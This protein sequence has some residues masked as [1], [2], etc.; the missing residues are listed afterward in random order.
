MIQV[1]LQEVDLSAA[2]NSLRDVNILC[3]N[4]NEFIK[5]PSVKIDSTEISAPYVAI[6]ANLLLVVK[7]DYTIKN[8][9]G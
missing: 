6:G 9:G 3:R 1:I 8:T 7:I 2:S 5:N 4:V